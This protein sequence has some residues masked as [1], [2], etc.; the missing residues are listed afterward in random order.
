M[1]EILSK[2][3]RVTMPDAS[4]WDIPAVFLAHDRAATESRNGE[5][6]EEILSSALIDDDLLLEWTGRVQWR[7]VARYARQTKRTYPEHILAMGW[8]N[9]EKVIVE[10]T[11]GYALPDEDQNA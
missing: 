4:Q 3:I 2:Q 5:E 8:A 10:K 9:G 6:Y 11:I 1:K 7:D